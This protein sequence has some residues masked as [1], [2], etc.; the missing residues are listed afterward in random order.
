[1][2]ADGISP[3]DSSLLWMALS[4]TLN[5]LW[6]LNPPRTRLTPPK[7]QVNPPS[8]NSI[9]TRYL[10]QQRNLFCPPRQKRFYC[11][12]SE[13]RVYYSEVGLRSGQSATSDPVFCFQ[14]QKQPENVGVLLWND[15]NQFIHREYP[16]R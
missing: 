7:G 14:R 1:M 2:L 10:F 12:L 13:K 3:V 6:D 8:G 11:I 16:I 15:L 5:P 4:F 9:K